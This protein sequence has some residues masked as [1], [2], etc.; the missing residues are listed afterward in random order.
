ML[1]LLATLS[2]DGGLKYLSGPSLHQENS[3]DTDVCKIYHSDINW[4][5]LQNFNE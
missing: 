3:S 2:Q 5:K 1:K 4:Q